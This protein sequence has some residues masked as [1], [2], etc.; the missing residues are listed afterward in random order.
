MTVYASVLLPEPLG[1]MSACTSPWGTRRSTPRRISFSSTVACSPRTSR[2]LRSAIGD[3]SLAGGLDRRHR[4][5]KR[6]VGDQL[7]EG[8][9]AQHQVDASLEPLPK[10]SRCAFPLADA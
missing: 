7:S 2:A 4:V 6:V 9:L 5:D 10:G 8:G 1:P 3:R